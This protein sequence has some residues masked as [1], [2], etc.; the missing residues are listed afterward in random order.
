MSRAQRTKNRIV[1]Q[2]AKLFNQKG[3]AGASMSDIMTAA[4]IKK[5]GIYNHFASKEELA[6]AAFDYLA[7]WAN[8]HHIQIAGTNDESGPRL[9]AM[10][11]D[12]VASYKDLIAL[13]GCPLVNMTVYSNDDQSRLREKVRGA[14]DAWQGFIRLTV[15]KAVDSGEF[16]ARTDPDEVI[17]ILISVLEGALIMARLYDDEAY[18]KQAEVHINSYIDSLR[19][20]YELN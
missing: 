1:E 7:Q 3:I 5:G 10:A 2:A 11:H 4:D 14:M 6:L 19:A 12:F 17:T 18:M 9:K 15:S 16:H 20:P 8:Q 13:G